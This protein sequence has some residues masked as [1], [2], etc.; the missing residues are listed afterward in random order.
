[1]CVGPRARIAPARPGA[2]CPLR[3]AAWDEDLFTNA[4]GIYIDDDDHLFCADN[5][6]H[7]VRKLTT[8]GELSMTLGDPE[9]PSETG[10][11]VDHSPVCCSAGPFNM[12]T[13]TAVGPDGDLFVS[14]GYGNARVHRFSAEG[15]LKASWGE[16]GS[17]PDEFNLPHSIVV[18]R[19]GRVFVA[20]RENS[21]HR[22]P[23]G[24]IE[25]FAKAPGVEERVHHQGLVADRK[26]RL[27]K[28]RA[29]VLAEL[30]AP[31]ALSG[32]VEYPV[33]RILDS[34]RT[35][36]HLGRV[37]NVDP[38]R[39]LLGRGHGDRLS[40]VG[41]FRRD[42]EVVAR[43]AAPLTAAFAEYGG[44]TNPDRIE[45]ERFHVVAGDHR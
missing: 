32:H 28:E 44:R 31:P 40:Q 12:V 24:E 19:S 15:E 4:H 18:D 1:M 34:I 39:H 11:R 3:D 43:R 37:A 22:I 33:S 5:Y 25:R 16:P 30:A 35:H 38:V 6:D 41:Q 13:N 10:F 29:Q 23:R 42:H 8:D 36:G 7:T 20:D 9:N 17:G 26:R 14:D 21:R 45:P 27:G 2:S